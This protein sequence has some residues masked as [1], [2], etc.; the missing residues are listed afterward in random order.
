M[1][2][3]NGSQ[4]PCGV[5][6]EI[7]REMEKIS[8]IV[9]VYNAEKYIGTCIES[10]VRQ[11]YQNIEIILVNDGSDDRSEEICR[12]YAKQDSRIRYREQENQGVSAARNHGIEE[13]SGEF[14]MF[15]D[16]DDAIMEDACERLAGHIADGIDLVLCG[17]QRVFY[18]NEHL[19]SQYE[20]LPECGDLCNAEQMGKQFGRL[21]ETT[22]LTS[23][24]AKIYRKSAVTKQQPVF[25]EDLDLGE[26]ALFNLEFL[27][28]CGKIAVEDHALYVYNQRADSGSITKDDGKS[29]LELSEKMLRSAETLVKEKGIYL[30]TRE[31][32]WKVYYKDCMNYLERFTFHERKKYAAELL[33]RDIFVKTLREERSKSPDMRLYHFFLGSRSKWVVSLFAETRKTAKRV[34]RG[35]N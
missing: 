34:L 10:M 33:K 8:I 26:D 31:R 23:V 18:R 27:K 9:P 20:V 11:S 17:F 22:L 7:K 29:R 15:V 32:L 14:L 21:Y 19:V 6:G 28:S 4:C 12:A 3:E 2:T 24:W 25:C 35:G 5:S 13:A 1:W 30:Q 16:A